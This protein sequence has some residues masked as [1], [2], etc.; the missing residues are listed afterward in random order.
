MRNL[1]LVTTVALILPSLAAADQDY[2]CAGDG[3]I[4]KV[5][6]GHRQ[7][8]ITTISELMAKFG[9]EPGLKAMILDAYSQPRMQTP[10]T[11]KAI[12]DEF[13]NTWTLKCYK[14]GP[15]IPRKD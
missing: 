3:M 11:R 14:E 4:A 10:E 6:A 13:E 15:A 8:G 9:E 7:N 1:L 5:F 2:D 12:I